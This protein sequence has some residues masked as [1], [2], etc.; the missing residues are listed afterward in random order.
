[1]LSSQLAPD[2]TCCD[3]QLCVQHKTQLYCTPRKPH[4]SP[5]SCGRTEQPH[6]H[7]CGWFLRSTTGAPSSPLRGSPPPPRLA[8]RAAGSQGG[9]AAA[10]AAASAASLAAAA[11]LLAR[12]AA[13]RSAIC[14]SNSSCSIAHTTAARQSALLHTASNVSTP[15]HELMS[16]TLSSVCM[17]S[18]H[19]VTSCDQ[20]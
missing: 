19:Q 10:L 6:T 20:Q 16:R 5:P 18:A 8:I 2:T 15:N 14:C 3:T 9:G 12:R 1:M 7:M 4:C 17:T 11:A 13:S